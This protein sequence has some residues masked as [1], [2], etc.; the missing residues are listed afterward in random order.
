LIVNGGLELKLSLLSASVAHVAS[1]EFVLAAVVEIS[2]S[3]GGFEVGTKYVVT[4]WVEMQRRLDFVSKK[5]R[6]GHD[7]SLDIGEVRK[8]A[9]EIRK[10][11]GVATISIFTTATTEVLAASNVNNVDEWAARVDTELQ[12]GISTGE[13]DRALQR[14]CKIC[15]FSA[16]TFISI[17]VL[18]VDLTSHL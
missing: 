17:S 13:F 4:N 3:L 14:Q 11:S 1:E 12:L 10:L 5:F 18:S 6:P 7:L 9:K 8:E 16:G 2:P 15:G